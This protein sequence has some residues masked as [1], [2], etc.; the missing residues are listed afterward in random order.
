MNNYCVYMKKRKN[1]PFCKLINEEITFD[2]C[3]ECVNKEYHLPV[4]RKMVKNKDCT[5]L[6]NNNQI[7]KSP[8]LKKKSPHKSGKMKNK[9]NKLAKL[10]RNRF[11]I[12]VDDLTKCCIPNCGC[13]EGINKHEIFYGAYRLTSIKW[14]LVI[15]LCPFHHTIGKFAIHNNRELDLYFKKLG[16]TIFEEKYSHELFMKEFVIDYIKKYEKN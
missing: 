14:G 6:S 12:I 4:S 7:R 15:P 2:R 5:K 16:Q 13:T 8:L 11:S 1:K 9:S 10:E 3:R